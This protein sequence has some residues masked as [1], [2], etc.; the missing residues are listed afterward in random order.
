MQQF[1][2]L[3]I[4]PSA[5][6]LVSWYK[7][8][9]AVC[10]CISNGLSSNGTMSAFMA[11]PVITPP[12]AYAVDVKIDDGIPSTGSILAVQIIS[13]GPVDKWPPDCVTTSAGTN[14]SLTNTSN[15]CRLLALLK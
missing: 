10:L 8:G 9:P 13:G 15:G 14:Y 11:D 2:A 4:N 6:L 5:G 12:Q 7:D 3:A 1:P